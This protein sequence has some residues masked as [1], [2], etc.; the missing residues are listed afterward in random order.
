MGTGA[1]EFV[2]QVAYV[3]KWFE[4]YNQVDMGFCSTNAMRENTFRLAA[5]I[6]KKPMQDVFHLS[7]DHRLA[8]IAM[9]VQ[10]QK[11]LVKDVGHIVHSRAIFTEVS[12]AMP[13]SS[14]EAPLKRAKALDKSLR[15]SPRLKPAANPNSNR[16]QTR[17]PQ[18][19]NSVF[20][21]SEQT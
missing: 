6:A 9:P 10:M 18:S 2:H 19:R 15:F 20:L 3:D 13:G 7:P 1:F 5:I 8:A 21:S 12:L 11:D 4:L 16:V 17:E 14:R